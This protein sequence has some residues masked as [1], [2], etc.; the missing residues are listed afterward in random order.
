[1]CSEADV[2]CESNQKL[3]TA[4]LKWTFYLLIWKLCF[5]STGDKWRA[6][7]WRKGVSEP[8]SWLRERPKPTPVAFLVENCQHLQQPP[9]GEIRNK[10]IRRRL[11]CLHPNILIFRGHYSFKKEMSWL[12]YRMEVTGWRIRDTSA[13]VWGRNSTHC[14]SGF[15]SVNRSRHP[16]SGGGRGGLWCVPTWCH[17]IN[18]SCKV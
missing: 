4:S 16:T 2:I 1:M 14:V 18:V 13:L 10:R 11:L 3:G 8:L 6:R 7:F 17:E 15:L 5:S 9:H 12:L